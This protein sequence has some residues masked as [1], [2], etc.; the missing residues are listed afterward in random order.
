[1]KEKLLAVLENSR[2]YTIAVADAMPAKAYNTKLIKGGWKFDDLL[3]HIGYGIL[4]WDSN[5][6]KKTGTDWDPPTTPDTKKAVLEY[7]DESYD[8]LEN[9]LKNIKIT[10]DLIIGFNA[11]ID[12]ITLPH[13]I[14][15]IK[16]CKG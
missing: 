1:M 6:I 3:T 15:F 2:N 14:I 5:F 11:T 7:I 9:T 4:W 8:T 13:Q 10:D 16:L 12:H